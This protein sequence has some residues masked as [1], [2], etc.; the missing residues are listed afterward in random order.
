MFPYFCRSKDRP[1]VICN[2]MFF[3]GSLNTNSPSSC[4]CR[5]MLVSSNKQLLVSTNIFL[6]T[7]S[8]IN[9][10]PCVAKL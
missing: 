8:G 10:D 9:W 1:W 7:E 6:A 2:I 5:E 4:Y 3:G